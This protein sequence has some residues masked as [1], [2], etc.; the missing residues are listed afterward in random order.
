VMKKRYVSAPI[1]V[2]RNMLRMIS[3]NVYIEFF[4]AEEKYIVWL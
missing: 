4:I 2:R 1:S 3:V